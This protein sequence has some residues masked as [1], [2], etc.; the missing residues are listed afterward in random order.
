[1]GHSGWDD[2]R[3]TGLWEKSREVELIETLDDMG[4]T[5]GGVMHLRLRSLNQLPA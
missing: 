1:M 3:Y 2:N 4:D 5:N